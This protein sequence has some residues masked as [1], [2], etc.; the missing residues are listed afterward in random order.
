[1]NHLHH[2]PNFTQGNQ[3]IISNQIIEKKSCSD[4][5]ERMLQGGFKREQIH[6]NLTIIKPLQLKSSLSRNLT[7]SKAVDTPYPSLL[8]SQKSVS[9]RNQITT[10]TQHECDASRSPSERPPCRKS[11]FPFNLDNSINGKN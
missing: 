7:F 11:N 4:E 2:F 6:D 3:I 8:I 9:K 5:V 10:Q 1:M